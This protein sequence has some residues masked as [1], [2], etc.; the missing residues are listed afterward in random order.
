M[1]DKG[2]LTAKI[3]TKLNNYSAEIHKGIK[4]AVDVNSDNLTKALKTNSPR[5]KRGSAKRG[6]GRYTAGSYA[7]SWTN[8]VTANTFSQYEKTTKNRTHYQLTHLLEKGH[9]KRGGGRVDPRVHIAPAEQQA[10]QN[11][12][13][14][15]ENLIK[16]TK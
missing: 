14:D 8:E 9:A 10:E 6:G 1:A 13:N 2:N 5:R 12:I 11:F 7:R 3:G 15:I 16:N 4:R